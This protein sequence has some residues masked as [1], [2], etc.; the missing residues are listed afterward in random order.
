[1]SALALSLYA[2]FLLMAGAAVWRRPVVALYVFIVGLAL[3]NLVMALLYGAGIRGGA[4]DAI[5]AWKEILLAVAV[6]RVVTDAVRSRAIP[7]HPGLAD[8]LALAFAAI[9]VL[10]AILPQT[11]LG[12]DAGPKAIL[13]GLR[14]ALVP[15]VA[16]LLG[17]SLR[18]TLRDLRSL[19]WTFLGAAAALAAGGLIEVYAVPV[20]W[21]KDSGAVGYFKRELGFDYHGPANLPD[22]FAFNTTEGLFR[23]LIS[24]FISPL[25]TAFA[26]VVSLLLA[27]VAWQTRRLRWLVVALVV[28]SFAGLLWT[29]SR[30]SL[31]A[32]AGG[33]IVLAI[34]LRRAWPVAA[35][36]VVVAAGIGFA[37]AF[38]DIAPRTHWFESD[39]TYQ[40]ARAKEKGPLPKDSGLKGT[41]S[42]DEPSIKSHLTSLRDGL[43]TVVRH[44]Q[45]YGLGNAG[46]TASR[47]DVPIRAGESNY[48]E[49]GVETGIVGMLLLIAWSL[50]LLVGL[51]RAA[52]LADDPTLRF[53]TAGLAAAFA[54]VLGLA[55]QTDIY[56]VPWIAYTVWW[57]GGSLLRPADVPLPVRARPP[58]APAVAERA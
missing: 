29:I 38:T 11:A 19:G 30:S 20:E 32:L 39:R 7:F 27:G 15:V 34:A 3:H 26:L 28:V 18:L 50:A 47:F 55:I 4:L 16:Y 23:R 41:Y 40:E 33:L 58:R 5:Q 52:W 42:L 22:N 31:A 57:L 48:T 1:V 9:V 44:P 8:W 46:V 17:R 56:G 14:H 25:G 51:V 2:V 10:Y 43:E 21:W 49:T 54:A 12:G 53:A 6:A 13:Y 24:S 45:G 37:F 35:A 36:V